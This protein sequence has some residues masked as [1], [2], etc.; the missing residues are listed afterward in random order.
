[1]DD[2]QRQIEPMAA[3]GRTVSSSAAQSPSRRDINADISRLV[4]S[5][6][7]QARK[8]VSYSLDKLAQ[9]SGVSRAMLGQI[10]TAK[11]V[12]TV[13]VLWHVAQALGIEIAE[14]MAQPP[15]PDIA[16]V[17]AQDVPADS[18]RQL[19]FSQRA[20]AAGI[21]RAP[22]TIYEL[23][24]AAGHAQELPT[25]LTAGAITLVVSRG[26]LSIQI[27]SQTTVTLNERDAATFDGRVP[28]ILTNHGKTNTIAYLYV[29]SQRPPN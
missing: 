22:H 3:R 28:Q 10:E 7:R 26:V 16:V 5:N 24:L 17:R 20:I 11:S 25:Q 1:M 8:K 4:G 2:L 27:G 12:P 19:A 29:P 14:L 9:I 21:E 23:R 6:L 13:T 18:K 15:A